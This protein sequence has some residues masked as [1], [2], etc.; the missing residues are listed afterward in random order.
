MFDII[1]YIPTTHTKPTHPC[2]NGAMK[3]RLLVSACLLPF[4]LVAETRDISFARGA[5]N[6]NDWIAVKS[7]RWSYLNDFVQMDDHIL[8]RTPDLP[9]DTI[10]KKHE[11]DVFSSIL[12]KQT[13]SLG[14]EI[15][16]TMSFDHRMAPLIV[17]AKPLGTDVAGRPEFREH[18]E[19]VLYDE[20]LNVWHHRYNDGKPSWHLAAFLRAPFKPKTKYDLKISLQKRHGTKQLTVSCAGYV[21]GYEDDDLPET[22]QTGITGCE[23]RNRF[24][25]FHVKENHR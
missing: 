16:A 1:A 13:F 19:I 21:F 10:F 11:Q 4:V 5:W 7:P 3:N 2:Y 18:F 22:F 12:L 24:Y 14:S 8:N 6:T 25:S 15:S 20:G 9:D 23:G 17:I